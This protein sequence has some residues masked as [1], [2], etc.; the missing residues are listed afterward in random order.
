MAKM[1]C[2][3]C[4]NLKEAT[5][6]EMDDPIFSAYIAIM[7]ATKLSKHAGPLGVCRECMPMYGKMQE[8]YNKKIVFYGALGAVVVIVYFYFTNNIIASVL[9]GAFVFSLAL[10]QYCPPLKEKSEPEE[11]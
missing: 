4:K 10:P 7:H 11:I 5:P 8:N 2:S 9:I 3:L 6:L 1:L